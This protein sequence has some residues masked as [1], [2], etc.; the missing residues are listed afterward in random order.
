MNKRLAVI[1]Q[2]RQ[3]LLMRVAVQRLAV[4]QAVDAWRAPLAVFDAALATGRKLGRHPW[5]IAFAAALLLSIPQYR[6]ALWTARLVTLWK[7][8][9]TV[10][11]EWPRNRPSQ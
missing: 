10:Q 3:L 9:R 7:L 4:V 6:Y 11:A 5:V 2:R 8:Y 1:H